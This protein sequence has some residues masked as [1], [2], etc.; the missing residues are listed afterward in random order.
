MRNDRS[1]ILF[2]ANRAEFFL[3]HRLPIARAVQEKGFDVHV[4]TP[5]DPYVSALQERGLVWHLLKL[6]GKSLNPFQEAQTLLHLYRLYRDLQPILVHHVAFKAVLHGGIA[7][8]LA[9]VPNVVNAFTGLGHLFS[10]ESVRVRL[11]RGVVLQLS[12]FALGHSHSRTIFQNAD[13]AD[14]FIRRGALDREAMRLI[15]GSGVDLDTFDPLPQSTTDLPVVILASRLVWD[16]GVGEF[17]E[18]ARQL[19]VEGV[20]ARFVLVG[21]SDPLNPK[22]VPEET[23]EAWNEKGF[24]E[25]WGFQEDMPSVFARSHIVC[26]PSYYREGVPKVLIEAAACARPIVTTDMP[27]CREIVNDGDNGLLVPPRNSEALADALRD[28]LMISADQ[29]ER[30][31]KRGR[32]LVEEEFS[33]TRVVRNTMAVYEE[34]LGKEMMEVPPPGPRNRPLS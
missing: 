32:R 16:K 31:G 21:K 28:I 23:L 20:Q 18:A 25:W 13:N 26:L 9:H 34:L 3:S 1:R 4:A 7:A 14:E 2:V 30:M 33:L 22:A 12:R 6:E 27:G 17:V 10:D 15:K 19:Q 11:V 5:R 8:R 29:R 24:V